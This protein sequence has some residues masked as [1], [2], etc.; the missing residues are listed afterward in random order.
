[1]PEH[2]ERGG[3]RQESERFSFDPPRLKDL[4]PRNRPAPV[5]VATDGIEVKYPKNSKIETLSEEELIR[6]FQQWQKEAIRFLH[7]S[8]GAAFTATRG[9]FA[10]MEFVK[11]VE[12][13]IF[14]GEKELIKGA[15]RLADHSLELINQGKTVTYALLR[16]GGASNE[17]VLLHVLEALERKGANPEMLHVIHRRWTSEKERSSLAFFQ[18][19]F[20]NFAQNAPTSEHV[21]V[22]MDDWRISGS[23]IQ[24]ELSETERLARKFLSSH[25]ARRVE[26]ELQFLFEAS[27][28]MMQDDVSNRQGVEGYRV[29]SAFSGDWL[30]PHRQPISGVWTLVDFGFH[31]RR[32]FRLLSE[33]MGVPLPGAFKIIRPTEPIPPSYDAGPIVYKREDLRWRSLETFHRWCGRDQEIPDETLHL[34]R[35]FDAGKKG[36]DWKNLQVNTAAEAMAL[37]SG[38]RENRELLTQLGLELSSEITRVRSAIPL[39]LQGVDHHASSSELIPVMDNLLRKKII[40]VSPAGGRLHEYDLFLLHDVLARQILNERECVPPP[41]AESSAYRIVKFDE[42]ECL[43]IPASLAGSE[44]LSAKIVVFANALRDIYT[45]FPSKKYAFALPVELTDRFPTLYLTNANRQV[46]VVLPEDFADLQRFAQL[47]T[48]KG[49]GEQFYYRWLKKGWRERYYSPMDIVLNP[50]RII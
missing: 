34:A 13:I 26:R 32:D 18:N 21:L 31:T 6:E 33:M 42:R 4:D 20:E 43:R 39:E 1:M 50:K 24:S 10:P 44:L 37:F 8:E 41:R 40:E 36:R 38:V 12:G 2:S 27:N 9:P 19:A 45:A 5:R 35:A 48:E 11:D 28:R 49:F 16:P 47:L 29:T 25:P 15:E 14:F 46:D 23:Q 22:T 3:Y 30:G 17:Y 7:S